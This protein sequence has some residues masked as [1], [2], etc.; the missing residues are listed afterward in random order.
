M[1]ERIKMSVTVKNIYNKIPWFVIGLAA[2]IFLV[3]PYAV[4][5]HGVYIQMN[6]QLDGEVLNYIYG[7]KYMFSGSGVVP[8]LMNG[9]DKISMTPPAPIGL[10]FYKL[11]PPFAAF[12]CMHAFVVIIG[13]IGMYL[14]SKELTS[15]AFI[16]FITAGLFVYLPF[17]PVYGLSI[18]G[19][20]L[21]VWAVIRI[22]KTNGKKLLYFLPVIMYA[23]SSSFAL[24]GFAWIL[25]FGIVWV[26]LA[27]ESVIYRKKTNAK[28][29]GAVFAVLTCIYVLCNLN[30]FKDMLGIG[31][32]FVSHREEMVIASLDFFDNFRD[33]FFE[34]GSY[35]KSY[36]L[37]IVILAAVAIM[38][39]CVYR[40]KTNGRDTDNRK[41]NTKESGALN[42]FALMVLLLL[43]ALVIAL[44]AALWRSEPVVN[45]RMSAGGTLKSFQADRIYWLLPLCWYT[46]LALSLKETESLCR[47]CIRR[48][49]HILKA[50]P[51]YILSAAAF[52]LVAFLGFNI[53]ENSTIYHNLRLMI[54]P[55]TYHLMDWDDY[56]AED[57]YS[58]IDAFIGAD[59]S[60]YRTVSLGITPAA[61]LY[62]GFYCLD[63]YSNFYPLEYKHEFRQVIEK[64]L[65][66]SDELRVYF[67][68]WGNRCY[69]FNGETGN[70]MMIPGSNGGSFEHLEFNTQK[71][72]EMGG[73]YIFSALP[74]ENA[75]DM[76]LKLLRDEPFKTD[77]SYYSIWLYEIVY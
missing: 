17:Y 7:A 3:I 75:E 65:E 43:A 4:L 29:A 62:N 22:F 11:L 8:E 76:N 31:E 45:M 50:V 21:L 47:A 33:I 42:G 58:Q 57:V 60:E 71:L 49:E 52:V 16:S 64:E 26:L 13:Y 54:F 30:L 44:L 28:A 19:Q 74:I 73:R 67:D 38:A 70:Y 69:L 34:G 41:D 37:P 23:A 63:G 77:T 2:A 61:A 15:S 48:A 55:D 24:V 25:V 14:L 10:I 36:N 12:A 56:Y 9:A 39:R 20:P 32:T 68:A 46:I 18:L 1:H 27:A 72:Y 40:T 5:G 66:K 53:Y 59:K 6:D 51:G 35:A